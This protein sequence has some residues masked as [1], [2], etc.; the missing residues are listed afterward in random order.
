MKYSEMSKS[1]LESEL[2]ALKE[3]YQGYKQMGLSLTMARGNPCK[4]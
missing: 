2:E 4:E 1:E 3:E